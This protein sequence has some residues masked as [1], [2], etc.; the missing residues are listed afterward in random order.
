MQGAGLEEY[1]LHEH[2]PP[3][4]EVMREFHAHLQPTMGDQPMFSIVNGWEVS[5]TRKEIL[6]AIPIADVL[7]EEPSFTTEL[8]RYRA[9]PKYLRALHQY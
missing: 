1:M 6:L 5:F 8:T 9:T 4:N 2:I 7:E 3:Y